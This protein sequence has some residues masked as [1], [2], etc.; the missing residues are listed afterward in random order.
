MSQETVEYQTNQTDEYV[1]HLA[2][3][4]ES[5]PTTAVED[6]YNDQGVLLLS[7]GSVITKRVANLLIHHQLKKDLDQSI[8]VSDTLTVFD[9][10]N[11]ILE[12]VEGEQELKLLHEHLSFEVTLRQQLFD[13]PIP[14]Q[15]LQR[16]TVMKEVMPD[17]YQRSLFSAWLV[18]LLC[19]H[20]DVP[21][22]V[23]FSAFSAGLAHDIGLMHI[24]VEAA[25]AR[26]SLNFQ[27]WR[28]LKTHP[29]VARMILDGRKIYDA[30]AL[31]AVSDHHERYDRSGYPAMKA[32]HQLNQLSQLVGMADK[33]YE[34]YFD[35]EHGRKTI[36]AWIPFLEVNLGTFGAENTELVLGL[37]KKSE[38]TQHLHERELPE[39]DTGQLIKQ[40]GQISEFYKLAY[41]LNDIASQYPRSKVARGIMEMQVQLRWL[42]D[43]AGLGSDHLQEWLEWCEKNPTDGSQQELV[44]ISELLGDLRWRF[45]RLWRLAVE[46]FWSDKTQASHKPELKQ[47]FDGM[48]PLLPCPGRFDLD[49][50]MEDEEE[51]T[52]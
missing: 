36:R 41:Q 4:E 17:V 15:V 38:I 51:A 10:L 31:D 14:S 40:N 2:T 6:I 24:P 9:L 49:A 34:L 52:S 19:K 5:H 26:H 16:L 28:A 25:T 39:A 7:K 23:Y 27:Q 30:D 37:L 45:R 12:L 33:L 13:K 29:I 50:P 42:Q 8:H 48:T 32:S 43:S 35:A 21:Q 11:Q 44:E 22:R 18:P 1:N 47:I 20:Q 46:L 3:V